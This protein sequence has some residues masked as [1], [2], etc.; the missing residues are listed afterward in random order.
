MVGRHGKVLVVEDDAMLR[1]L[2]CDTL[3]DA[4]FAV[5]DAS[6]VLEAVGFLGCHDDIDV[7]FSDIDLPGGLSGLD[8]ACLV[9]DLNPGVGIILTS[10]GHTP[11]ERDLPEQTKFFAKPYNRDDI[12]TAIANA[13]LQNAV[14]QM[15]RHPSRG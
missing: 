13:M 15:K 12:C 9:R 4:G 11:D 2:M 5:I 6:S 1:F 3:M 10:G 7:V 8:L 14:H